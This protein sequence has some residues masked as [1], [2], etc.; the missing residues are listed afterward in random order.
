MRISVNHID[1]LDIETQMTDNC[2]I[3]KAYDILSRTVKHLSKQLSFCKNECVGYTTSF[4]EQLGE[5]NI[6]KV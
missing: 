1:H 6:A 5:L 3:F 4:V 2:D